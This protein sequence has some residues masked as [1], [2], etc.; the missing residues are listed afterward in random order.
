MPHSVLTTQRL[1][2][3]PRTMADLEAC[4]AMDLD[5]DVHRFIYG[6]RPPDPAELR[7]QLRARIAAAWPPKGGIWVVEWQ[8]AP[9]FLGWCGL[10][11]L[12]TSGLIEI[13]YR[14]LPHAWGQGIAT[15]AARAVLD[16]GFRDLCFD[17][18]VAV[19]HPAN[20]A[21]RHVLEKIGLKPRG[22]AFHYGQWLSFFQLGRAEHLAAD[23]SGGLN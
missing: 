3:R 15:E 1:R 17:P 12:E 6:N 5:P 2:L 10:F 18:I 20:L 11:P 23:A 13:G 22:A 16:H 19:A 9:G 21:S 4:V 7:A 14:Y 8:D